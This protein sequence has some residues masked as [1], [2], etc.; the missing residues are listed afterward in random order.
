M[1]HMSE[2]MFQ[3]LHDTRLAHL[4]VAPPPALPPPQSVTTPRPPHTLVPCNTCFSRFLTPLLHFHYTCLA[5]LQVDPLF[6]V[7]VC[8]CVCV[9]LCV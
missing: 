5:H 7:S 6:C 2:E 1:E 8:V 4:Q 3:D 9:C